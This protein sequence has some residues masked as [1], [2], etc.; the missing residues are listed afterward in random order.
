MENNINIGDLVRL[1]WS[2]LSHTMFADIENGG[3]VNPGSFFREH[4]DKV[5]IV[6]KKRNYK[7]GER[8]Y[9][10][11]CGDE[12]NFNMSLPT[13]VLKPAVLETL[14]E[15]LETVESFKR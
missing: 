6:I 9:V 4:G 15:D 12:T 7:S 5:G 8:S 11:W 13:Y 2:T 14:Q 10:I 1:D 3:L